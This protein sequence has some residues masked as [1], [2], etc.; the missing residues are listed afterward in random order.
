ML[1]DHQTRVWGCLDS[2][3]VVLQQWWMIWRDVGSLGALGKTPGSAAA[4]HSAAP[5]VQD[6]K[7]ESVDQP[8]ADLELLKIRKLVLVGV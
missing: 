1:S 2:S 7:P 5:T 6:A 4:S 8:C 3:A